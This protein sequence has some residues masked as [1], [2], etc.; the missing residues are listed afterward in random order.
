[1][2]VSRRWPNVRTG[3]LKWYRL[4]AP[5]PFALGQTQI[6]MVESNIWV[7]NLI[8]QHGVMPQEGIP[9]IRYNA[10]RRGLA[11]VR[12]C[13]LALNASVHMPRIGCGLAG[14]TWDR[15]LQVIDEELLAF[16]L[17]VFVYDRP[18]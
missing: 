14:G 1:M 5:T 15:M 7:V 10:V 18:T 3:Y 2:E 16:G 13:A 9:P 17:D 6:A 8:G 12:D 11:T 4:D